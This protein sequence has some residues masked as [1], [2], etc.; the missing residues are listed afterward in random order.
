M[1]KSLEFRQHAQECRTL[2]RTTRDESQRQQLM[3]MANTWDKLAADRDWL[4]H[5]HPD[6]DAMLISREADKAV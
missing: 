6:V 5:E 1:Q 4:V 3:N 2:A